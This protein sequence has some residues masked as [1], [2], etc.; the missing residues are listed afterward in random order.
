M[1]SYLQR[2][3]ASALSRDR[4]I[5]PVLGSLWAPAH[6]ANSFEMSG[7]TPVTSTR[8]QRVKDAEQMR[9]PLQAQFQVEPTRMESMQGEK[10]Q[11]FAEQRSVFKPLLGAETVTPT[12]HS[13][14]AQQVRAVGGVPY[15]PS[16]D[17]GGSGLGE[18]QQ[19]SF[20]PLVADLAQQTYAA[21]SVTA[22]VSAS[23]KDLSQRQSFAQPAREPDAI[24][25]HIGRIEVLAKQPQ[26]VQ[27]PPAQPA[28]KSLD[29]GEYLR[30]GGRTR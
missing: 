27:R 12:Q 17:E 2:M 4:A 15:V 8:P 24:E 9:T 16:Q 19:R 5:H 28:L 30:R 3:A 6:H 21:Q 1:K 14:E 22:P 11:R 26:Q 7:E 10:G 23:R 13:F 18:P 20:T 29:L 25:I